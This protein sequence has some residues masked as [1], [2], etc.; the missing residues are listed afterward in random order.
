MRE[1]RAVQPL[2]CGAYVAASSASASLASSLAHCGAGIER[3]A[4]GRSIYVRIL[5][6]RGRASRCSLT[7]TAVAHLGRDG[8]GGQALRCVGGFLTFICVQVSQRSNVGARR[9]YADAEGNDWPATLPSSANPTTTESTY[10]TEFETSCSL[11]R[12]H[13]SR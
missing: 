6:I 1:A 8:A 12:G 2:R 3:K 7:S 5:P 11:G 10:V 4:L 9:F 13:G